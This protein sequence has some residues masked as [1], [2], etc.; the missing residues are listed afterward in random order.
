MRPT[1][2]TALLL[3]GLV[4]AGCGQIRQSAPVPAPAD[5]QGIAGD[6]V[7]RGVRIDHIVSGDAGCPDTDL[8]K[9]AIAFDAVGLDQATPVR[10]YL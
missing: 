5:F 4:L 8:G 2:P 3:A 1:V 10:V 7:Q 6:I 9:T